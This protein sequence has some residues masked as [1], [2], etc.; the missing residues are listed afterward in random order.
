MNGNHNNMDI[1]EVDS[2]YLVPAGESGVPAAFQALRPKG[3][4]ARLEDGNKLLNSHGKGHLQGV[5]IT[6]SRVVLTKDDRIIGGRR[7]P[8]TPRAFKCDFDFVPAVYDSEGFSH[9][10]GIQTIGNWFVVG[11]EEGETKWPDA[12][13]K[14][15]FYKFENGQPK[16]QEHLT[17]HRDRGAGGIDATPSAG[18]AGSVG[19]TNYHDGN[20]FRYLLA[21][22][23]NNK[24]IH[25]YRTLPNFA[26]SD[27][28]C[29]FG[30]GIDPSR[31][32]PFC[33]WRASDKKR[34]KLWCPKPNIGGC[35]HANSLLAED[36]GALYLVNLRM[37]NEKDI[38]RLF[39]LELKNEDEEPILT[40]C[41]RVHAICKNGSHFR[42]GG[43]AFVTKRGRIRLFACES[44]IQD[45][46]RPYH[47]RM[48]IFK[49]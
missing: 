20:R 15:L 14:I 44:N 27:Q 38:A 35:V 12:R 34:K 31:N 48:N 1:P 39:R 42:Y 36:N 10:G 4:D 45:S 22:F 18:K 49:A 7:V 37:R 33:V 32:K 26:L 17:I 16:L 11:I 19:I 43:S 8:G 6:D 24:E 46:N 29:S 2:N 21:V 30:N 28:N 40:K 23:P 9:L 13:S 3:V 41:A 5:A 25:F 47:I